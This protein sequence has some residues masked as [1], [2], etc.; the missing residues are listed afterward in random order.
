MDAQRARNYYHAAAGSSL[1]GSIGTG[2]STSAPAAIRSP[3]SRPRRE[4][5]APALEPQ[6]QEDDK[7]CKVAETQT[8]QV[9]PPV[10][11]EQKSGGTAQSVPLT[12]SEQGDGEPRV[13]ENLKNVPLVFIHGMKG[14]ALVHKT[15]KEWAW[16]TGNMAVSSS[17]SPL[18]LELP[19]DVVDGV[20]VCCNSNECFLALLG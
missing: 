9:D 14:S 4:R 5:E 11:A 18:S 3:P 7:E 13:E 19:L 20:Q 15:T 12:F 1:S 6:Q 17:F 10:P 16:L 2:S 8:G